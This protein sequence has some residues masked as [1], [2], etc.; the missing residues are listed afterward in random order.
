MVIS[1]PSLDMVVV[2]TGYAKSEDKK[3]ELP[4]EAYHIID[5]ARRLTTTD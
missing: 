2:R 3:R 1:I 4:V 5:M